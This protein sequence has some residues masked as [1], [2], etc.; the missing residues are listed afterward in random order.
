MILVILVCVQEL[1]SNLI[2]K[3]HKLKEAVLGPCL[4]EM[5]LLWCVE[6]TVTFVSEF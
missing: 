2:H 1:F 4:Y 5:L 3:E 6:V